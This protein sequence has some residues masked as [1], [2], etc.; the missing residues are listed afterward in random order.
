MERHSIATRVLRV[1]QFTATHNDLWEV[2]TGCEQRILRDRQCRNKRSRRGE[3]NAA[4]DRGRNYQSV[5]HLAT[6]SVDD[7]YEDEKSDDEEIGSN[8]SQHDSKEEEGEDE[9]EENEGIHHARTQE[10][11]DEDGDE[12]RVEQLFAGCHMR[13]RRH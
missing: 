4:K 11:E 2:Q 6:D 8:D 12:V 3:R 7:S 10:G 9:G 1:A 5:D 13:R